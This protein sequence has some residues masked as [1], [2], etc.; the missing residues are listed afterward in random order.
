MESLGGFLRFS[1]REAVSQA[2]SC[3]TYDFADLQ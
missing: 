3:R 2:D 1:S